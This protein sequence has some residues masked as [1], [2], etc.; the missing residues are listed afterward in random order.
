[1][2]EYQTQSIL[3]CLSYNVVNEEDKNSLREII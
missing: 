2:I 3:A 1:M